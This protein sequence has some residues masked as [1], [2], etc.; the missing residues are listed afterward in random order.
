LTSDVDLG[1]RLIVAEH[2]FG[3]RRSLYS[4]SRRVDLSARLLLMR[5]L[6]G[7]DLL[8]TQHKDLCFVSG[9]INFLLGVIGMSTMPNW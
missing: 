2:I 7:W 9:W 3:K 6:S 5:C 4:L 8:A 1:T